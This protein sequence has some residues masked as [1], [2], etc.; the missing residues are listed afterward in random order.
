MAIVKS[1]SVEPICCER[2]VCP[3]HCVCCVRHGRHAKDAVRLTTLSV[4][5]TPHVGA[6]VACRFQEMTMSRVTI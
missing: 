4:G 2:R 5:Q 1:R 3:D 6:H